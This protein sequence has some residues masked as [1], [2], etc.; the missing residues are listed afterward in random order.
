MRLV[1]TLI[2]AA[3]LTASSTQAF[4]SVLDIYK[5]SA[6]TDIEKIGQ[7]VRDLSTLAAA[8]IDEVGL[9]VAIRDF[10]T[11]PW[12]REANGLHLWGVTVDG[13]HW[14][15]AGHPEFVGLQVSEMSDILGRR[16]ASTIIA[17]ATGTG[18]KRFEILFP[19]PQS[20]KAARGFHECFMLEDGQR[21]LCAGAFQ[22]IE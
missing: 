17:S 16:W 21:A 8:H 2:V 14:F 18:P 4:S 1:T 10:Q 3:L 9:G 7:D 22:D 5:R 11:K 12:I 6:G 13:V 20:G 19:H 15:D